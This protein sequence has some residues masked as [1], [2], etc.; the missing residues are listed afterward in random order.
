[1]RTLGRLLEGVGAEEVG[2]FRRWIE[3]LWLSHLSALIRL[4]YRRLEEL[5]PSAPDFWVSD[6]ERFI[7]ALRE[8]ALEPGPIVPI[9]VAEEGTPE[10]AL[11]AV[12]RWFRLYGRLLAHWPDIMAA[13]THMAAS[14]R[15]PAERVDP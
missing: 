9:E 14:G 11:G 7:E 8:R 2:S 1:M 3:E 13:A 6:M 4:H 12:Q 5:G 10:E 15:G